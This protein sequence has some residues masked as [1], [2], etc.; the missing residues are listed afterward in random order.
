MTDH[1]KFPLCTQVFG[2]AIDGVPDDDLA[3]LEDCLWRGKVRDSVQCF[4]KEV[5]TEEGIAVF[6]LSEGVTQGVEYFR[7]PA[8]EASMKAACAIV[9]KYGLAQQKAM[10]EGMVKRR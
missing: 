9:D 6:L 7:G 3:T 1:H 4:L 5:G 2:L 10:Q 8:M